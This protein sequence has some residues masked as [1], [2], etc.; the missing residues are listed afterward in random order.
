MGL[1]VG[2]NSWVTVAEADSYLSE[3]F[4]IGT[5]WT[6]LTPSEKEQALI[7]AY[8]WIQS[9]SIYTI[10]PSSTEEKVKHAQ[11]ELALYV[12]KYYDEHNKRT[13]LYAQGVRNFSISKW[14]ENLD[15]SKLPF[16]V[17]DLLDD[18]LTGLGGQFPEF[19]RELGE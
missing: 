19:E 15:K 5:T 11:I 13:A 2:T 1:T 14:K 6:S 9:L 16:E 4:G 18:Y 3:K 10:S 7:T 12:V 8:R 17:E